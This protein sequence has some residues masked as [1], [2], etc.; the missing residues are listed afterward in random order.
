MIT[1]EVP[2]SKLWCPTYPTLLQKYTPTQINP[3]FVVGLTSGPHITYH[4]LWTSTFSKAIAQINHQI[5]KECLWISIP[6]CWTSLTVT[7]GDQLWTAQQ[8]PLMEWLAWFRDR[9][10]LSPITTIF[11]SAKILKQ[12]AHMAA[13]AITATRVRRTAVEFS[14]PYFFTH[15]GYYTK[16]PSPLSKVFAIFW[17]YDE[18]IWLILAGTLPA[19]CITYWFA[20]KI[21]RKGF[22]PTLSLGTAAMET[23]QIMIMQGT[24][25]KYKIIQYITLN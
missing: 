13:G 16:K 12:E 8:T 7:S 11:S 18:I 19:F 4:K 22:S 20:S 5:F 25:L 2:H 6:E 15:I 1:L 9:L 3:K 14:Y 24:T 10:N 21:H 23:G 17:P